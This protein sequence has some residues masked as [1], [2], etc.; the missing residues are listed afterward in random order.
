MDPT[1][2]RFLGMDPWVG[3]LA[4]PL[5]SHRFIAFSLDPVGRIDPSGLGPLMAEVTGR[6]VSAQL[7]LST[8]RVVTV[9]TARVAAN[10][11]MWATAA[12]APNTGLLTALALSVA[13]NEYHRYFGV[14][15]IV[16]GGANYPQHALHIAEA[17]IGFGSNYFPISPAL[18]RFFPWSRDWLDYTPECEE[19]NGFVCD[20]YPFASSRQGGLLNYLGWGVSLR[21]LNPSE[22]WKTGFFINDFYNDAQISPDGISPWSRFVVLGIPGSRS[23]YTDRRGRVHYTRY[24]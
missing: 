4:D 3:I 19:R 1:Q 17:Q 16:F 23:F 8:V 18:N 9:N 7:S 6:H 24:P 13:A 14:P 10:D 12:A 22:S 2:G 21:L 20:E 15:V 11:A 5:T